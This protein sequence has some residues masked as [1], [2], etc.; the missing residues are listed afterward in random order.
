[1][2]EKTLSGMMSQWRR[3]D[4]NEQNRISQL[5]KEVARLHLQHA[6]DSYTDVAVQATKDEVPLLY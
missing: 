3:R 5:E 4:N 2:R 1:M 6:R